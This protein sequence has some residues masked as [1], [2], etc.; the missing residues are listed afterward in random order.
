MAAFGTF[1]T[2]LFFYP[3]YLDGDS[4]WQY[5]QAIRGEFND[6]DPAI[7]AWVWSYLN[8]AIEGSGGLFLLST[9]CF[10]TGLA[11][12]VRRFVRGRLG[13]FVATCLVGF[14]VPN[15]AMLSQVQKDVGMVA[16]LLL[17][18][19]ALLVADRM[20]SSVALIVAFVSLWY[21]L[22]VRHNSLL[23]VP[24]FVIW[25]GFLVVRDYLPKRFQQ[26]FESAGSKLA[27]GVLIL[28]FMIFTSNLSNNLIL[29]DYP[30]RYKI[31]QYETLASYDLV[32]IAVRSGNNYIPRGHFYPAR[33]M[34]MS[35]LHKLYHPQTLLY[36]YWGGQQERYGGGPKERRLPVIADQAMLDILKAAWIKAVTS[37]P[38]AY[39]AHRRDLFLAHLG[40]IAGSPFRTVQFVVWVNYQGRRVFLYPY[41]G[42]M[43]F[44]TARNKW[45]TGQIANTAQTLLFRPWPYLVL[46]IAVLAAAW[47]RRHIHLMHLVLLGASS[48][49]YTLPFFVIGVSAEF[50][51]LWWAVLVAIV[52]LVIFISAWPGRTIE[53]PALRS[54]E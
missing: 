23:A 48:F 52:Q 8:R 2:A 15:F 4:T 20:R 32:G 50:R 16:T 42:P 13:F 49:L 36:L 45:L 43:V 35:E 19:G 44:E 37:E 5:E 6:K 34:E 11:V 18:Y 7:M 40:I 33:P 25:M 17:G 22:S 21:A 3:G 1:V 29:G 54:R 26:H 14:F 51:Y 9:L 28:G 38:S 12:I 46:S 47:R 41:K 10:W 53:A 30:P 24:P 39:F 31:W 27:V